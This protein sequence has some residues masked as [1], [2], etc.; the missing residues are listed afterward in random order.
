MSMKEERD[1]KQHHTKWLLAEQ[2]VTKVHE[3]EFEFEA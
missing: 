3:Q 2:G 1:K